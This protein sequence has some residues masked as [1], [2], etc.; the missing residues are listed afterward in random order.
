MKKGRPRER[1]GS[2]QVTGIMNGS[3][4]LAPRKVASNP[5][6]FSLHGDQGIASQETGL[7]SEPALPV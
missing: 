7:F 5:N 6:F 3:S 2:A 1:K 4:S